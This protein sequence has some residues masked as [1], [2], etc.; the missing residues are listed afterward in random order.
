MKLPKPLRH[1]RSVQQVVT[2]RQNVLTTPLGFA[3]NAGEGIMETEE[4]AFKPVIRILIM[5]YTYIPG[6]RSTVY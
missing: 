2:V 5:Q 6:P 1:V 4:H 3:V